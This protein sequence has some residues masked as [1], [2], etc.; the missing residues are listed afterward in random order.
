MFQWISSKVEM[1]IALT[2]LYLGTNFGDLY[3]YH[4]CKRYRN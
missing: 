1:Q 4:L 2:L 3:M